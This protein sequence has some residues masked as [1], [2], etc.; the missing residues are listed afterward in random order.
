MNMEL[1][2]QYVTLWPIHK[3]VSEGHRK[4]EK[5]KNGGKDENESVE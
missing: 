5:S 3:T 1:L 4:P 2:M